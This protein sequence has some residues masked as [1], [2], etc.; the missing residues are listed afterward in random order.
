[1]G[2]LRTPSAPPPDPALEAQ[3]KAEQERLAREKQ[4]QEDQRLDR[5]RKI[6]S[7]LFGAKSL[8]GEDMEGF[9]GYRRK[10]MGDSDK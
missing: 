2:F 7:N 6:K 3:K 5:E 10:F 1:M 9:G 4:M 8:Q